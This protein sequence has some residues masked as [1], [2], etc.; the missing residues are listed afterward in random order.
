MRN[1]NVVK[2][3]RQITFIRHAQSD[4]YTTKYSLDYP[5]DTDITELGIQEAALLDFTFDVLIIS[6]LKRCLKTLAFS[7]IKYNT[8]IKSE[9]FK[10]KVLNLLCKEDEQS[11]QNRVTEAIK[12]IN[13]TDSLNIGI[14]TH[15]ILIHDILEKYGHQDVSLGHA[16]YFTLTI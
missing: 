4:W 14:I 9:L 2:M 16:K 3:S 8:M 15:G 6:P 11:Y 13:G 10:E 5:V 1:K 7:K 12:L